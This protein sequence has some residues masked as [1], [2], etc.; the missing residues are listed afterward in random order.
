MSSNQLT[1]YY[2]LFDPDKPQTCKVGITKNPEQRL[3]AYRTAAPSCT[4]LKVFNNIPKYHEKRI[5]ELLKD[6]YTV[7]S[8]FVYAPP[9]M[10]QNIVEGYFDDIH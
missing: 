8:E 1:N 5:L 7:K 9:K 3:K 2:I 6:I 4:F 10:I